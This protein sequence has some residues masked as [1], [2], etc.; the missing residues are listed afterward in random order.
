[1]NRPKTNR[2]NS[3][4]NRI[5]IIFLLVA[6][7]PL[8][9]DIVTWEK[10]ETFLSSINNYTNWFLVTIGWLYL[11]LISAFVLALVNFIKFYEKKVS[12]K[13]L[14]ISTITLL[15]TI[16]LTI[17]AILVPKISG[18]SN[19]KPLPYMTDINWGDFECIA[20]SYGFIKRD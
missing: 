7:I 1:M 14:L 18:G 10:F 11:F 2:G 17:Y 20:L 3:I 12:R 19:P 13:I 5:S 6:F 9:I 4:L 8:I 16:I 15:F